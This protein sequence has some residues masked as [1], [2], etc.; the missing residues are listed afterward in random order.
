MPWPAVENRPV[1]YN[2]LDDLFECVA[3]LFLSTRHLLRLVLGLSTT[4]R[5]R[6][7]PTHAQTTATTYRR[8]VN[9]SQTSSRSATLP[10]KESRT[11][12][13]LVFLPLSWCCL[14]F[15]DGRRNR[16]CKKWNV[17]LTRMCFL[18]ELGICNDRIY[19]GEISQPRAKDNIST[20][21][22]RRSLRLYNER[23][24]VTQI[25][26]AG[27]GTYVCWGLKMI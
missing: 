19:I 23:N 24:G 27:T 15:S 18:A 10:G 9:L 2:H 4:L 3:L 8:E 25:Y 6:V 17:V 21:W 7:A 14:P 20:Q 1:T 5:V 13:C 26:I 12:S 16:S 22:N 11:I